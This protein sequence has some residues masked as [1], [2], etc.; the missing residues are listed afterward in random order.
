MPPTGARAGAPGGRLWPLLCRRRGPQ[1]RACAGGPGARACG[2]ARGAPAGGALVRL[3]GFSCMCL[4][5]R[6]FT[7]DHVYDQDSSQE[8]VYNQS[9]RQL[10]HSTLQVRTAQQTSAGR[11]AQLARSG[12][13]SALA[14]RGV[15]LRSPCRAAAPWQRSS[16]WRQ[17][18]VLR[19]RAVGLCSVRD[20][21]AP[22]RASVTAHAGIQRRHHRIRADGHWKD[23]HHGR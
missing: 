12:S 7:F 15:P 16:W 4:S 2:P 3:R 23:I 10:V 6:R 1:P 18:G 13:R 19:G 14:R 11:G 21:S 8:D 22:G 20:C 17:E 5:A 9:A